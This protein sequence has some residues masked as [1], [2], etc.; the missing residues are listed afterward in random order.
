MAWNY[1]F[2]VLVVFS[3]LW[4]IAQRISARHQRMF[5]IFIIIFAGCWLWWRFSLFPFEMLLGLVGSL[6]V[7]FLFWLFI[8]RYNPVGNADDESIT[9]IGLDD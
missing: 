6:V 3:L 2:G 1:L 4:I 8:G 5:R 9:V 7:S